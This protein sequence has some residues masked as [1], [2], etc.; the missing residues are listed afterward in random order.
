MCVL[1]MVIDHYGDEW[2][3]RYGV[4]QGRDTDA[5]TPGPA[6]PEPAEFCWGAIDDMEA[7]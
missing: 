3:R 6:A 1:S 2:R 7:A 4:S 5:G